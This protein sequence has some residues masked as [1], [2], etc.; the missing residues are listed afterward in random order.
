[1]RIISKFHDYYDVMQPYD[2]VLDDVFV[3]AESTIA[4][5]QQ[6]ESQLDTFNWTARTKYREN[7]WFSAVLIGFCGDVYIGWQNYTKPTYEN[8][9]SYF[10]ATWL[11]D[12]KIQGLDDRYWIRHD[13]VQF[14]NT[15]WHDL[16]MLIDAPIF[17]YHAKRPEI[18][19][20]PTLRE[21]NFFTVKQPWEAWQAIDM[22]RNNFLK[23]MPETIEVSDTIKAMKAGHGGKYSFRKIPEGK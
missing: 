4:I 6:Y 21:Y 23:H 11:F 10:E 3:R 19:I 2:Q 1:M 18:V 12:T 8:G 15:D 13:L 14:D 7:E 5:P 16:F 22:Y 17:S 9:N 20:N